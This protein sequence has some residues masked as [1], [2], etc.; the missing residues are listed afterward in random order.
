MR[1]KVVAAFQA[2]GSKEL[3]TLTESHMEMSIDTLQPLNEGTPLKQGQEIVKVV[4]DNGEVMLES[5]YTVPGTDHA[6]PPQVNN[7]AYRDG[8]SRIFSDPA[9]LN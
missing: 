6:G 7:E 5:L 2:K 4:E 9:S 1:R 3:V 8:W